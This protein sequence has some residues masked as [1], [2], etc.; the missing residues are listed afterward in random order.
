M[1]GSLLATLPATPLRRPPT[2]FVHRK[3]SFLRLM[4]RPRRTC[5]MR[6][7]TLQSTRSSSHRASRRLDPLL[8]PRLNPAYAFAN[9]NRHS[10]PNNSMRKLVTLPCRQPPGVATPRLQLISTAVPVLLQAPRK[11]SEESL[12]TS[13]K[14]LSPVRGTMRIGPRITWRRRCLRSVANRSFGD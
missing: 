3:N 12:T 2:N 10:R 14:A 5:G 7:Q 8:V 11:L 4:S 6:S 13:L 9:S 1:L